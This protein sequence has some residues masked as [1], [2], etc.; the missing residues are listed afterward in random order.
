MAYISQIFT[1]TMAVR[2]GN[3]AIRKRKKGY[4][5]AQDNRQ[6]RFPFIRQGTPDNNQKHANDDGRIA[7]MMINV[8]VR[9]PGNRIGIA[10]TIRVSS[11]AKKRGNYR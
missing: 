5:T 11:P 6:I 10:A 4:H 7:M 8:Y 3:S 9:N 2:A 1:R